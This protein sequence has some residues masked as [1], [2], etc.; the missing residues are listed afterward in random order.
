VNKLTSF[1]IRN[2]II[3]FVLFLLITFGIIIVASKIEL[4]YEYISSLPD[5]NKTYQE[6][7]KNKE[8]FPDKTSA[9]YIAIKNN[10]FFDQEN[11]KQEY[12]FHQELSQIKEAKNVLSPFNAIRIK[13]DFDANKFV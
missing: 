11:L 9:I 4:S 1:I 12:A 13:A 2:N 5:E 6:Y 8:I 3:L 10:Y 7:L